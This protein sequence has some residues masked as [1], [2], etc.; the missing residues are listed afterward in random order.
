VTL[1]PDLQATATILVVDDDEDVRALLVRALGADG[2]RVEAAA[3]GAE[4]RRSLASVAPDLVV[5]D[6]TLPSEDGLDILTEL[7]ATSDVPVILLSG[8]GAE[9]DRILGLKLGADDY[10]VKP[11]SP[12]ELAARIATVLRRSRQAPHSSTLDF[13]DLR[14]DLTTREVTVRGELVPMTAKEFDL[15]AYLASSPRQVFGRE[16]LLQHVWASS[17]DWQ[18]SATVTEHVRRVRR[19]IEADPDNPRWVATIRGVGYRFEP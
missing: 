17:S 2:F 18:D 5:L 15:L 19:K 12:G 1:V 4:A 9:N 3:D 16:Q 6:L 14:I 11:F 13:G 7:R 10:L 8:R